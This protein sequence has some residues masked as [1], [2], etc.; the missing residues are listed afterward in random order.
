MARFASS[1]SKRNE[2]LSLVTRSPT[3]RQEKAPREGRPTDT[4]RQLH[5]QIPQPI[6][7]SRH[8]RI[9]ESLKRS[10][11][12]DPLV[13]GRSEHVQFVLE[14]VDDDLLILDD[15]TKTSPFL[16]GDGLFDLVGGSLGGFGEL[17]DESLDAGARD[18]S[19][20]H[21]GRVESEGLEGKEETSQM[22]EG[23][24]ERGR[25]GSRD[26]DSQLE[27]P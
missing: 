27:R 9:T 19:L 13:E 1:A 7:F 20:L 26:E 14:L 18:G 22:K 2:S 5:L 8:D 21:L 3:A 25:G 10:E 4:F 15:S 24:R 17:K 16:L 23:T 11:E 12:Q 6:H